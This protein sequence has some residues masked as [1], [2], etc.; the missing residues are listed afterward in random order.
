[1]QKSRRTC[2]NPEL[3]AKGSASD[4]DHAM[5]EDVL[6]NNF[7]KHNIHSQMNQQKSRE[8]A[9]CLQLLLKQRFCGKHLVYTKKCVLNM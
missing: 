4:L 3:T 5:K 6:V 2:T 8:F 1:V 9:N 7:L